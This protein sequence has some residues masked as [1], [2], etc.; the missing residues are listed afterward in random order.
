MKYAK[1]MFVLT[2][3]MLPMFA[4]AQ[5]RSSDRIVTKVPFEFVVGKKTIP[6]GECVVQ[7]TT[8]DLKTVIIRNG[9][10]KIGLFSTISIVEAAKPAGNYA[11]VFHQYG[12]RYFLVGMKLEGTRVMYRLPESKAEMELRAQ[13]VPAADKILLAY[14][15]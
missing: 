2:V 1:L 15:Q 3:T 4:A 8:A 14:L 6:A 5:L 13:N 7:A 10:A 11:L 12:D 9:E